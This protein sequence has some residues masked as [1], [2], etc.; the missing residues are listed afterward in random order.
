[1]RGPLTY[2]E[3]EFLIELVDKMKDT[4]PGRGVWKVIAAE[5]NCHFHTAYQPCTLKNRYSA[6]LGAVIE[7]NEEDEDKN[8]MINKLL[9]E[10][11]YDE[12]SNL[13]EEK[14]PS[15]SFFSEKFSSCSS[16]YHARDNQKMLFSEKINSMDEL[17]SELESRW[18][19]RVHIEEKNSK[20]FKKSP[21]PNL[22]EIVGSRFKSPT[23]SIREYLVV[24]DKDYIPIWQV[25]T[26]LEKTRDLKKALIL[27]VNLYSNILDEKKNFCLPG[28]EHY[29][30]IDKS[31]STTVERTTEE[32]TTKDQQSI[33]E[34]SIKI[35]L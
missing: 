11:R 10:N 19:R 32:E 14:P 13:L 30:G 31:I 9:D 20:K 7:L 1:V 18:N 12:V 6:L 33:T 4:Y 27:F 24:G 25:K 22:F 16:S 34:V 17:E 35:H 5:F 3:R 28:Y 8:S 2:Q 26:N 29:I 23:S 21:P 15:S